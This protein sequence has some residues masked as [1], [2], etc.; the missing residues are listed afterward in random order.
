MLIGSVRF[1]TM[2]LM[3]MKANLRSDYI[4]SSGRKNVEMSDVSTHSPFELRL[5]RLIGGSGGSYSSA[6]PPR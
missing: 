1:A 4:T 3:G 6:G 5:L 2:V